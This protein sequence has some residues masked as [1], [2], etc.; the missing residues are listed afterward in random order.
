M[1]TA[2]TTDNVGRTSQVVIAKQLIDI[3]TGA[4]AL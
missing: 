3:V 1:A 2:T 4:E